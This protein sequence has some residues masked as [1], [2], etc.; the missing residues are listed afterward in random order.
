VTLP[1]VDL[2]SFHKVHKTKTLF[3]SLS[4][5]PTDNKFSGD[6]DDGEEE[7]DGRS[8]SGSGS[9]ASRGSKSGKSASRAQSKSV[10]DLNEEVKRSLSD[11]FGVGDPGPADIAVT[12]AA[13]TPTMTP[14][15]PSRFQ[16][17]V[18][19]V[20]DFS[21]TD[22]DELSEIFADSMLAS[23]VNKRVIDVDER[24][25][26]PEGG[27]V[28]G[29]EQGPGGTGAV[30]KESDEGEEKWQYATVAEQSLKPKTFLQL[31]CVPP[32]FRSPSVSSTIRCPLRKGLRLD[33]RSFVRAREGWGLVSSLKFTFTPALRALLFVL[34][35][36]DP[37]VIETI[38]YVPTQ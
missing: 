21:S 15:R 13:P 28:M 27:E 1:D 30:E 14:P 26:A 29:K 38:A 20:N 34:S 2:N 31:V 33:R 19:N 36:C 35:A 22:E 6:L 23:R 12:S 18:T 5:F 10:K 8:G 24:G 17:A 7:D 9:G 11:A 16:Y 4:L 25:G 32:P 3:K 37:R